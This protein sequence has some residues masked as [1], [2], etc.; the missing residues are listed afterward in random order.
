MLGM[1]ASGIVVAIRISDIL[2]QK[3]RNNTLTMVKV[4]IVLMMMVIMM[5]EGCGCAL[6][7]H[8]LESVSSRHTNMFW[9]D[10]TVRN[11]FQKI[12]RDDAVTVRHA[13]R[14]GSHGRDMRH[15]E[16]SVR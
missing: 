14:A 10:R 7:C 16:T 9:V 4:V 1:S 13:G 15:Q 6:A 8:S 2:Q 3:V 11:V 12:R 5:I